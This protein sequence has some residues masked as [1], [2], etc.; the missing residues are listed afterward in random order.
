MVIHED[1]EAQVIFDSGW[2]NSSQQQQNNNDIDNI[3][4]AVALY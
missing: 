4:G 2:H 1:L 3:P